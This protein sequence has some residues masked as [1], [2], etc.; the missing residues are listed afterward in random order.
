MRH[1]SGICLAGD[2]FSDEVR[3][4]AVNQTAVSRNPA[5]NAGMTQRDIIRPKP[6]TSIRHAIHPLVA[7]IP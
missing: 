7:R 6:R 5:P 4:K 1:G 2:Q 3:K